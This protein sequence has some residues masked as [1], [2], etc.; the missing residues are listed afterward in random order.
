MPLT[1]THGQNY[2][3][4]LTVVLTVVRTWVLTRTWILAMML[5]FKLNKKE[6]YSP[7]RFEPCHISLRYGLKSAT[8]LTVLQYLSFLIIKYMP[9]IPKPK[10]PKPIISRLSTNY[11]DCLKCIYYQPWK[12]GLVDCPFSVVPHENCLTRKIKCVKYEHRRSITK[13]NKI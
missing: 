3:R 11:S 10:Q 6:V 13:S 9:R 7:A 2:F 5:L 1:P 12:F 8:K 4:T